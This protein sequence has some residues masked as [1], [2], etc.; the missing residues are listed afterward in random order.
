MY[1]TPLLHQE[2]SQNPKNQL[3]GSQPITTYY[4]RCSSKT[5]HFCQTDF[6]NVFFSSDH[7]WVICQYF[8]GQHHNSHYT[9]THGV[10]NFQAKA[11]LSS[12]IPWSSYA[13]K[14][15]S[16]MFVS[17]GIALLYSLI[18]NESIFAS[19]NCHYEISTILRDIF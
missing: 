9:T 13:R 6:W 10:S 15:T 2:L 18:G 4:I 11:T 19:S 7:R 17:N 1:S 3:S 5:A 12:F 14:S 8:R 16:L